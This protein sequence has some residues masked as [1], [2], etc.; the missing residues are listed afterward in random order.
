MLF[1]IF[2]PDKYNKPYV[3]PV[4]EI[5]QDGDE[6]APINFYSRLV[7]GLPSDR[8]TGQATNSAKRGLHAT[9]RLNE[10]SSF[11][12]TTEELSNSFNQAERLPFNSSNQARK[13]TLHRVERTFESSDQ[14]E[15]L[16]DRP[17]PINPIPPEKRS[18][19]SSSENE[20]PET[21]ELVKHKYFDLLQKDDGSIIIYA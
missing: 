2:S 7:G 14:P 12:D 6:E 10:S 15:L 18:K 8:T 13:S 11:S 5:V 19:K 9:D 3:T 21:G 20:Q 1:S 17:K 4:Y 16:F